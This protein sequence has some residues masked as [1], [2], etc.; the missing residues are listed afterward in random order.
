MILTIFAFWIHNLDPFLVRFSNSNFGIRWYGVAYVLGFLVAYYL[1]HLYYKKKRS[2]L[3][4]E[5]QSSFFIA[6]VLGVIVGGRLGY[7]LFYGWDY[8]LAHPLNVFKIWEGGMS[9]HGGFI[10]V[11]IAIYWYSHKH[12]LSFLKLCD[13]VATLTPP[14][15]LF[16][17]IANFINGYLWGKV[18]DVPWAVIF[19][20]SAPGVPVEL[21]EPRHPSQL[22][23]AFLEGF[24]LLLYTQIRFWKKSPKTPN[25][26]LAGEFLIG[27]AILR[28]FGELFRE[29]D[30]SLILG[31]SRGQFYSIF[32]ILLGVIFILCA[33]R[34]KKAGIS[35]R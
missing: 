29:P 18:S 10:G 1:L 33:Y 19:P 23:A 14:G 21:I 25:G 28:I 12:S 20:G 24:V 26:Q 3:D 4:P 35:H 11:I 15:I 22:Y 9:S 13:M 6:L 8:L 34:N 7:M 27:Y 5:A 2:P 17:R 30:A 32:L 16:G 31:I